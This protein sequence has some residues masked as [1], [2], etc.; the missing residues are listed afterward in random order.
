MTGCYRLIRA[1]LL[2]APADHGALSRCLV[3]LCLGPG[4]YADA[5]AANC[6]NLDN[7]VFFNYFDKAALY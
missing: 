1:W 6:L 4:L 3:R 5:I 7:L 2:G